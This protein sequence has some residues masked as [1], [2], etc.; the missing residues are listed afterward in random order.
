MTK[1]K[2]CAIIL[3]WN[4]KESLRKVLKS[5]KK[6]TDKQDL[7][8][9]KI[10]IV[11]NLSED[12]SIQY[13]QR[14]WKDIDLILPKERCGAPTAFNLGVSYAIKKYNPLYL[15]KLDNDIQFIHKS[16]LKKMLML[17]KN[18]SVGIAGCKIL[19]PD[20]KT[21]QN[22]GTGLYKVLPLPI[23]KGKPDEEKYSR[24]MDVYEISGAF[25]LIKRE[26]MEKIGLFDENFSPYLGDDADFCLRA[27]KNGYRII[28]NGF[29]KVIHEEGSR[30]KKMTM[31]KK[32]EKF[33]IT[34]NHYL[35]FTLKHFPLSFKLCRIFVSFL[36]CFLERENHVSASN[37]KF[38]FCA[39]FPRRILIFL[40]ALKSA[41]LT[42]KRPKI[43]KL[44]KSIRK[45]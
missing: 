15:L 36:F 28:V 23:G 32:N 16:W 3:N 18:R 8:K 33:F 25:M 45:S 34:L 2:V 22:F 10:I 26:V 4:N 37:L 30:Y 21:V 1:I 43:P 41:L 29:V 39:N 35:L 9:I 11:D 40:K 5:I 44:T 19:Y 17:M 13:I 7:K 27:K 6:Y 42:Y 24:I 31:K 12:S 14:Y 20:K 38:K